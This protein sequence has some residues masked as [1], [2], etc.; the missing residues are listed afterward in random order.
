MNLINRSFCCA[1]TLRCF[2]LVV[3]SLG[4]LM[5]LSALAQSKADIVIVT[6]VKPLELVVKEL[7]GEDLLQHI[8]IKTLLQG[9]AS[10]HHFALSVS[11]ARALA[12]ADLL[13]WVGPDFELFLAKIAQSK[14]TVSFDLAPT[15]PARETHS[16]DHHSAHA[17][18]L[19]LWLSVEQVSTFAQ[20]LSHSLVALQPMW[21]E[22]VMGR[23]QQ[24]EQGL[25]AL[26]RDVLAAF[27]DFQ[28]TG[29]VVFHEAYGPLVERYKLKQL[30][31][32]T[33]VPDEQI[34]AK[35]VGQLMHQLKGQAA[36]MLSEVGEAQQA[37][38]YAQMLKLP[39]VNVDI[40]ASQMEV[41]SY[42]EYMRALTRQIKVCGSATL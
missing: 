8:E 34:S 28:A 6:S 42:S 40:L 20:K 25:A 4:M 7:L 14:K 24:F 27:S 38:R 11:Q 12:D 5:S 13:L 35:R 18:D 2:H 30:G 10:P 9:Q 36:C 16:T 41:D 19:H 26:D 32:L 22:S 29:F 3:F 33:E 17:E 37:S 31:R 39:L 21:R 1:R 23:L 15:Q